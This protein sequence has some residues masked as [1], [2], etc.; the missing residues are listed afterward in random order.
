M[1]E[2]QRPSAPRPPKRSSSRRVSPSQRRV[3]SPRMRIMRAFPLLAQGPLEG[4]TPCLAK[5]HA[6]RTHASTLHGPLLPHH[7]RPLVSLGAVETAVRAFQE[8]VGRLVRAAP[9]DSEAGGEGTD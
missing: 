3:P 9:G 4:D 5:F 2:A 1:P 7:A 6:P 8:G